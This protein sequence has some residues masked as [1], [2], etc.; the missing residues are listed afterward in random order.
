MRYLFALIVA[1]FMS[2][3]VD[4]QISFSI[5]VDV[6]RQPVWVRPVTIT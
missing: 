4:A 6:D 1:V 3:A 5:G 2:N